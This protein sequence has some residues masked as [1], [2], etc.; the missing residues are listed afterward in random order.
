MNDS[1]RRSKG[2]SREEWDLLVACPCFSRIGCVHSKFPVP[3]Y[4]SPLEFSKAGGISI[5]VA[6][7]CLDRSAHP[8][9][10]PSLESGTIAL[11]NK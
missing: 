7:H 2:G 10:V 11:M 3:Y 6:T 9:R 1:G 5:A 4:L 8:T